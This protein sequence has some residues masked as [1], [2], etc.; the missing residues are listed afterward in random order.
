MRVFREKDSIVVIV[1]ILVGTL[2]V[3]CLA[4]YFPRTKERR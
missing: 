3:T 2:Y 1:S 4:T